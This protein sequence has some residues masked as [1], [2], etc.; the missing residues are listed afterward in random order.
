MYDVRPEVQE[1]QA[2]SRE[3]VLHGN[4]D[5]LRPGR[6]AVMDFVRQHCLD[7]R[8]E[9]DIM[10]ALQEAL[11]NAILHGCHGDSSKLVHCTVG[12][13]PATF[14]FTIRDPGRGFDSSGSTDSTEEGANLTEHGR[15]IL[16]MRSLMDEVEYRHNGTELRL[17]KR[18]SSG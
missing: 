11:A 14:E 7:E 5:A 1:Q 15:G 13:S 17:V 12:I 6:D 2:L 10:L 9:I 18:R 4:L 3:F 8:Q 16:L